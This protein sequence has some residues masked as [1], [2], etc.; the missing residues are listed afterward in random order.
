V[1]LV[2]AVVVLVAVLAGAGVVLAMSGDD[3][4]AAPTPSATTV[5]TGGGSNTSTS[6]STVTDETTSPGQGDEAEAE[7]V[8]RAYFQAVIDKDCPTIVASA[9]PDVF[10]EGRPGSDPRQVCEEAVAAG[11]LDYGDY[12]LDGL[13]IE[14]NDGDTI[15]FIAYEMLDGTGYTET[16]VLQK[17][18]GS[19]KISHII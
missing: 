7:A 12:S 19:W 16:I 9:S 13:E 6:A 2:V 14:G 5:G 15:S 4:P 10:A 8:V 11:L 18:D 3:D 17:V 1:P